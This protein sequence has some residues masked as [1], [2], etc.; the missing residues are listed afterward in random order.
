MTSVLRR[1]DLTSPG[2]AKFVLQH[3]SASPF[4]HPGWAGL[5]ADCYRYP[6]FV[7]ALTDD[8]GEIIAGLPVLDVTRLLGARRWVS[9]P[10]TDYLP[11]L[12]VSQESRDFIDALVAS[13]RPQRIAFHMRA[14]ISEHSDVYTHTD[15]VRHTL[16]LSPDSAAVY[17]RFSTMHRRNIRQ[18]ERAGLDV[19]MGYSLTDMHAFY[20]LHLLTRKR[21]GVPVQPY[22][23]FRLLVERL[24]GYGLGFVL[25]VRVGG[26]A[27]AAAVFLSWKGT[28]T[29]KY[30]ASDSR[31]WQYRPNNLLFWRAI[32]WACENEYHTLDFGRTYSGDQGLREFKNGWGAREEP[33]VYAAIGPG[34][35][36]RFSGRLSRGLGTVIRHAPPWVCRA[37]G[38]IFYRYAA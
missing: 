35:S 11:L 5:L 26:A 21:L 12:E 6:A 37:I 33:L 4:H 29:Y 18:A 38:E 8:T 22:R 30:G 1:I 28:L 2:W 32:K 14:A 34:A 19:S 31:F 20:R 17:G 16:P 7:L 36:T 23:F 13:L 15:A 25:T 3:P 9:L 10:F 27:V 24:I